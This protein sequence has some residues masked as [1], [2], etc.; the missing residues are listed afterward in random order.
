MANDPARVITDHEQ[1]TGMRG[2]IACLGCARDMGHRE[3]W[4]FVDFK[5][6]DHNRYMVFCPHEMEVSGDDYD[7]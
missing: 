7:E 5:T 4:E 1:K 2:A 6:N 3:N